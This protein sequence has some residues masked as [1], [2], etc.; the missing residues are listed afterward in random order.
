M[1]KYMS[2][3]EEVVLLY[4]PVHCSQLIRQWFCLS[5]QFSRSRLQVPTIYIREKHDSE[6]IK[7]NIGIITVDNLM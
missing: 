6:N 2:N 7:N 1:A 4:T 5:G 3:F